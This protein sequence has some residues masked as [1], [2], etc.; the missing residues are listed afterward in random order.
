MHQVLRETPGYWHLDSEVA[1]GF[2]RPPATCRCSQDPPALEKVPVFK[3]Q[4]HFK[5]KIVTSKRRRG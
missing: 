4:K 1:L 5:A 2:G 3:I